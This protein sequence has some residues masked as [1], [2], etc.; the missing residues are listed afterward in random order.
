M[1]QRYVTLVVSVVRANFVCSACNRF[2]RPLN[3][4]VIPDSKL[5]ELGFGLECGK[6]FA[7]LA[8]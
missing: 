3:A 4:S 8:S 2:G 6:I 1:S 7:I 5:S